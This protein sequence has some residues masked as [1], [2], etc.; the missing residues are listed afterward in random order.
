MKIISKTVSLSTLLLALCLAG[1]ATP[2]ATRYVWPPPPEV[3]KIEFIG[4]YRNQ[5][6]LADSGLATLLLGSD[7]SDSL[8]NPL[9]IAADGLGKVYVTDMKLGAVLVFDFTARKTYKMSGQG[10]KPFS[11]ISGVAIDNEGNIYVGESDLKKIFVFNKNESLV[12]TIDLSAQLKSI[13]LFAIDK[14][15]K[16]L[17]IPDI[18]ASK[19]HV[20]DFNGK[21]ITTIDKFKDG[22]EYFNRPS[23]T[24]FDPQGNIIV[25][26]TM[27]ARIV[28]F[29]PDGTFLSM[30]GNRGD[31]P[32]DFAIIKGVAVDSEGHIYVTDSK[33]NRFNIFNEKGDLLLAIGALDDANRMIGGLVTPLG[34]FIDQND[35]IYIVEKNYTRFQKYQYLNPAYLARH[36]ILKETPLAKP[37]D[38]GKKDNKA[39]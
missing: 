5:S 36:P 11:K 23:A 24:A 37:V 4:T 38:E 13:G 22:K 2:V 12:S 6:D 3:A 16:R 10:S 1:C 33:S 31:N 21:V 19:V 29:A 17:V 39:N 26:D 8:M 9:A 20:V 25:T 35:T 30:F 28:R 18:A 32:G 15:R 27:N 7:A 34:I 14:T